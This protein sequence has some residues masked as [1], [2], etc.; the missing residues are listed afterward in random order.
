MGYQD[1]FLGLPK[2]A[3]VWLLS[4]L[5]LVLVHCKGETASAPP[6]SACPT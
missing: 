6:L 4:L 1:R 3:A 2:A 5:P